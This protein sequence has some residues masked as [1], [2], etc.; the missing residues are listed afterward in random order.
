VLYVSPL[1][2]LAYD[3]D[4][5]LRAPLVGIRRAAER[6]GHAVSDVDVAL[7]SG[8]TPADERRRHGAQPPDILITTPE[9]LFLLL[10]SR[11][12]E[13]LAAVE[14]VIV[15]EVHAVA[16]TKR[17]AHLALSLERLE[18]LAAAAR[19]A[20]SSASGLSATQRPLDE[21]A[22]FLGGG[23]VDADGGVAPRPV[24]VVEA[25]TRKA[26]DL[27]IVVPVEDMSRLGEVIDEVPSGPA[28]GAGE[29][30]R[31]IWPAV[32]PR[33]LD[34]IEAHRSTIV[35]ATPAASPSGCAPA[36][37]SCTRSGSATGSPTGPTGRSANTPSSRRGTPRGLGGSRG[38][39]PRPEGVPPIARAHHGSVARE[40]RV[41]IEE[42]LKAGELRCVVAT[43]SRW[44]SASTWGR[45]T[46]SSRSSRPARSPAGCSASAGPATRWGAPSVGKVFPK[47][48]G[49]LVECAVVVRRMRDGAIEET[50]YPRNPLDVL[51]QQVVAMAAMD[52][53]PVDRP[54]RAA[55]V[56][57]ELRR[58]VA[59]PA[60]RRARHAVGA[61]PLR[62]V[63][64]AAPAVNWDRVEDVITGRPA[65]SGWR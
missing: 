12:R 8:D 45:S 51:A 17:G 10:T 13:T 65:R 19:P 44:S 62:R 42:A 53:W 46:S 22:R 5:N 21:V 49:D 1:K 35:F 15:D 58:A 16:A 3:V 56:R 43:S 37:T 55:C 36:S 48:R 64:R 30:R 33:I 9:S 34:L 11:A 63:R 32:H 61:L 57:R 14:T 2:A 38:G 29:S 25:A 18:A 4:R 23:V 52:P 20:G 6:L 40:Q 41:L 28:A 27:E 50:R 31:S 24:E 54:P 47:F 60:R 7:R 39:A 26:L 59:D